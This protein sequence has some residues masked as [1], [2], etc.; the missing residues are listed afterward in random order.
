MIEPL[1]ERELEIMH[2]ISLG[3]TNQEIAERLVIAPSTVK[4]HINNLYAK[5]GTHSRTRAVAIA[6]QMGLFSG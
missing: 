5:L 2:L 3:L 1:S 6:R 4:S